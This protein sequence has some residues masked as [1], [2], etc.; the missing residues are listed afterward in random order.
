MLQS[1]SDSANVLPISLAKTPQH[2]RPV[3]Q[4]QDGGGGGIRTHETH[5]G[6]PAFEAGALN[7]T[8]RPLQKRHGSLSI[9]PTAKGHSNATISGA[10]LPPR[11]RVGEPLKGSRR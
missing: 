7:R 3:H 5:A 4:D 8:M 9:Y 6:L 10:L 11:T 1:H 2:C